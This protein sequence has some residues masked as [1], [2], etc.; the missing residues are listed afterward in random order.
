[1]TVKEKGNTMRKYLRAIARAK[2][3]RAGVVHI[4]KPRRDIRGYK[5]DSYFAENWRKGLPTATKH[6]IYA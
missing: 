6:Y 1:M 3:E 4:N 5:T 2:M